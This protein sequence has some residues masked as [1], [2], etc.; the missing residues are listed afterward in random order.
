MRERESWVLLPRRLAKG[1]DPRC[2]KLPQSRRGQLE[3]RF[4]KAR[5]APVGWPYSPPA[6][7]P[8][9]LPDSGGDPSMQSRVEGRVAATCT[10]SDLAI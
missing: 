4:L 9:G 2:F 1:R 5:P 7:D 6:R 10:E 8:D 3:G